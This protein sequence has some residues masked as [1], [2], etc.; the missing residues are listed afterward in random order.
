VKKLQPQDV[1]QLARIC[2]S[3]PRNLLDQLDDMVGGRRLPGRS[4]LIAELIRHEL[5]DPDNGDDASV[6]AGTIT[7]VYKAES[8][9]V[10]HALARL[11]SE[12]LPEV[13]SSQHVFLEG[14]QSLEVLLVQGATERLNALCDR[15]RS[16]R[17]VQQI[18]LVTTRSLLPPLHAHSAPEVT[19]EERRKAS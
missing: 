5:A 19:V 3:L 8:G 16:I 1:S 13:I 12:F 15:L 17:A 4:Q 11:Q 14:D 2:I 10:R 7:L 6:L 18:K 9:R